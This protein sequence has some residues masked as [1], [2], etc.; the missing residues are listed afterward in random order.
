MFN[1]LLFISFVLTVTVY[2]AFRLKR[3]RKI[4]ISGYFETRDTLLESLEKRSCVKTSGVSGFETSLIER[5]FDRLAICVEE[6]SES[7]ILAVY[8]NKN[9]SVYASF[10]IF[11]GRAGS[12]SV[13]IMTQRYDE[14]IVLTSAAAPD[15]KFSGWIEHNLFEEFS[16]FTDISAM[17]TDEFVSA[18]DRALAVHVKKI[19]SDHKPG[20][21]PYYATLQNYAACR[22]YLTGIGRI[23]DA[24]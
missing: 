1:Y 12:F 13:E 21:A 20:Y 16:C 7:V 24:G 9:Y 10:F 6:K 22:N 17:S 4:K 3:S 8:A 15:L 14:K 19:I 5:G 11:P 18:F 23:R 2:S